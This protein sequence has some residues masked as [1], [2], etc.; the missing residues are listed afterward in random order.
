MPCC[1]GH[2]YEGS[3]F[4]IRSPFFTPLSWAASA[5]KP[6]HTMGSIDVRTRRRRARAH[7]PC[8]VTPGAL[9]CVCSKRSFDKGSHFQI[10]EFGRAYYSPPQHNVRTAGN[11]VGYNRMLILRLVVYILPQRVV[12]VTTATARDPTSLELA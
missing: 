12:V 4:F 1:D 11:N 8:D 7:A 5:R 9:V 2:G 6:S 10:F 3:E